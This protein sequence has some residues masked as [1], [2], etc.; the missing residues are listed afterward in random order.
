[1]PHI[2]H[3]HISEPNLDPIKHRDIHKKTI[4]MLGNNGYNGFVSLEMRGGCDL[5]TV[6]E[7]IKYI[8]ELTNGGKA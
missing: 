6:K 8:K 5:A 7:N 1:V 4:E 3:V 2:S